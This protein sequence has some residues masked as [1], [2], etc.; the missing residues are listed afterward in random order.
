MTRLLTPMPCPRTSFV[1]LLWMKLRFAWERCSLGTI[2]PFGSGRSMS[3]PWFNRWPVFLCRWLG[4]GVTL[5]S[6]G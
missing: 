6:S 1:A 4:S 5:Q 3:V 2:V